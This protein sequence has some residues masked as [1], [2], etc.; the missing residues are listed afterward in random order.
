MGAV[1]FMDFWFCAQCVE[2]PSFHLLWFCS[3]KTMKNMKTTFLQMKTLTW[4]L[5]DSL[6]PLPLRLTW[7]ETQSL[8]K[9]LSLP[10]S[11]P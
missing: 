2:H 7:G 11:V 4:S 5:S 8:T 6:S 10:M 1:S 9:N 3:P